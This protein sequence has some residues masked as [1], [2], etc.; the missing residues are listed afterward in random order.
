MG[1]QLKQHAGAVLARLALL[2]AILATTEYFAMSGDTQLSGD[3]TTTDAASISGESLQGS[4]GA[5]S[6][7]KVLPDTGGA[8]L[9][10][11]ALGLPLLLTGLFASRKAWKGAR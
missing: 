10:R 9:W 8:D 11:A 6:G 4:D 7:V 3:A 5:Q 1:T 2:A